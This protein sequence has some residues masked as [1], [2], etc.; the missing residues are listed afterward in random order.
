[1][2]FH[3]FKARPGSLFGRATSFVGFLPLLSSDRRFLCPFMASFATLT[4]RLPGCSSRSSFQAPRGTSPALDERSFLF[5]WLLRSL[6]ASIVSLR[7]G[8]RS[9]ALWFSSCC[10]YNFSPRFFSKLRIS[11]AESEVLSC[12]ARTF[13][14]CLSFVCGATSA[15]LLLDAVYFL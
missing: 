4:Q 3:L 5:F 14:V 1:M 11:L 10:F 6:S 7:G 13:L 15:V 2:A 8:R 9:V 12:L